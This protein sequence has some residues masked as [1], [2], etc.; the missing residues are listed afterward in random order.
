MSLND[1]RWGRGSDDEPKKDERPAQDEPPHRE[2]NDDRRDFDDRQT[3]RDRRPQNQQEE[4]LEKLWKDFSDMLGGLMGS[5]G[6]DTRRDPRSKLKS[7]DDYSRDD[8]QQDNRWEA[9]HENR[10]EDDRRDNDRPSAG[11]G[12]FG[13]FGNLGNLGNLGGRRPPLAPPQG[14]L[15]LAGKGGLIRPGSPAVWAGTG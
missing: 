1:P 11:N 14:R 12:G 15:T 3:N 2:N 7:R 9:P 6:G 8:E 13:G 5:K 4:D 10:Y